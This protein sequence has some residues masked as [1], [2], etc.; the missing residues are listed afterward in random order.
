MF[1]VRVLP[2]RPGSECSRLVPEEPPPRSLPL[3]SGLGR[4]SLTPGG[5]S[6]RPESP[7][8]CFG[9]P[10]GHRGRKPAERPRGCPHREATWRGWAL[11]LR[12]ERGP[13]IPASEPNLQV[14]PSP[15]RHLPDAVQRPQAD[16]RPAQWS[17][18]TQR[19]KRDNKGVICRPLSFRWLLET[20]VNNQTALLRG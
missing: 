8:F 9:E 7:C 20:T 12:E 4:A 5:G 1:S 15:P 10:R 18:V 13:A 14:T 3:T 19:T 6:R 2:A 17:P 16:T 11:R